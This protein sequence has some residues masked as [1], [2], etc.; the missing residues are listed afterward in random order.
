MK[1]RPKI[2]GLNVLNFKCFKTVALKLT[3]FGFTD[4]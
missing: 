1:L 3:V 4:C 2:E